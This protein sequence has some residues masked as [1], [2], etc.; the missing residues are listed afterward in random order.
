MSFNNEFVWGAATASY[1]IEGSPYEDGKGLSIWDVFCKTEGKVYNGDTGDYACDSYHRWK[2]DVQ[3]LKD[4]GVDAYR[5]SLSWPRI[6]PTGEGAVNEVGLAFYDQFIDALVAEGITPYITLF[7]WDYP[8]DLYKKGGWLNRAS[9]DW[10]ETFT[11]IVTKRYGDRVKHWFTLNEPQ[12]F[13]A[14][15]YQVGEHAPGH[16]FGPIDVM[17]MTHNVLL[18]HGKAVKK[19]REN[20]AGSKIGFAP[21]FNP[22]MPAYDDPK[23]IELCREVN[24]DEVLFPGEKKIETHF[25]FSQALWADP[26]YLGKYPQWVFDEIGWVLPD[27]LEEDLKLISQ[28]IDFYGVNIYQGRTFELDGL[29]GIREVVKHE[30]HAVTGFDWPVTPE[31]LYWGPKYVYERYNKPVYVTENGLSM[32]DWVALDGKVHDPNRIDFLNRYLLNFRKAGEE[33]IDLAGY[34]Q[35]SLMDNFEWAHGYKQRFGIVHVDFTTG[36]R[37][38]KD[39]Y[40]WY[41]TVIEHNGENL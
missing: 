16:H 8:Y 17:T 15:G 19:I 40:Y 30:G 34:F 36:T 39:S 23:L 1:Q 31:A 18:S 14:L 20:V 37:T 11:D 33:G 26:V 24:F 38:P 27:T 28:P 4:L 25:A 10:F 3:L 13:I 41:K 5:F 9:A 29:G 2:E 7:H 22:I 12:I 35:W 21:A 32:K 6:M